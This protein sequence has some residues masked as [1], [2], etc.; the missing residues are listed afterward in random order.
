MAMEGGMAIE[1]A[2]RWLQM[3]VKDFEG[4]AKKEIPR[5]SAELNIPEEEIHRIFTILAQ[6]IRG[7]KNTD[8]TYEPTNIEIALKRH[9][10]G[11]SFIGF[12]DKARG[13]ARKLNLSSEERDRIFTELEKSIKEWNK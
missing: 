13:V 8:K 11:K 10:K 4:F 3:N 6:E 7:G 1:N 12:A 2:L 5:I 9:I